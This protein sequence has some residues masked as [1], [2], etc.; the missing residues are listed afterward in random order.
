[1]VWDDFCHKL[2]DQVGVPIATYLSQFPEIRVS[3][4]NFCIHIKDL[5]KTLFQHNKLHIFRQYFILL[6]FWNKVVDE[7]QITR[8]GVFIFI[9]G[10][11]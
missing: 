5:N 4:T 3:V 7:S 1:M 6:L 11:R 10:H 8:F 9:P 2:N